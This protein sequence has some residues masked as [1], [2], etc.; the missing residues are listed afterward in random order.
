MAAMTGVVGEWTQR[1]YNGRFE[2]LDLSAAIG[3]GPVVVAQNDPERV[4]LMFVNLS[5]NIIYLRMAGV[6]TSTVGIP[7]APNG[8]FLTVNMLED[9]TLPSM[10]WQAVAAASP[11]QLAVYGVRRYA[12]LP[13]EEV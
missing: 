11:S 1:E 9:L 5:V 3:T 7:L 10:Q 4:E 13:N 8:G 6:P 12:L 2:S